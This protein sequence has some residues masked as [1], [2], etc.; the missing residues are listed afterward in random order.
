MDLIK[1]IEI[2]KIIKMFNLNVKISCEEMV[3]M[4]IFV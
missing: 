1:V 3:D 2:C 4:F